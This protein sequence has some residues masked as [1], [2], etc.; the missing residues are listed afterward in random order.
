MERI[1]KPLQGVSNIVRFNWHFYVLAVGIVLA[2][3]MLNCALADHYT[4]YAILVTLIVLLPLIISLSVSFYVYDLSG[5]Y[6]LDWLSDLKIGPSASIININAGFDEIST[7]LHAR[8]PEASLTV[9]DFY[10]P[11]R[12]TEVSI[13]RARKAY[14]AYSGTMAISTAH[15]PLAGGSADLIFAV[16][17]AHEIRDESE[18]IV[19]FQELARVLKPNGILVLT[20]HLRDLPNFLAYNIG[21]FHFLSRASWYRVVRAAGLRVERER[22]ITPFISTFMLVKDG[23]AS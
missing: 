9:L 3:W 5:L 19:F 13:E 11:K 1:R 6:S 15:L 21:F 10:D 14:P 17:A 8:F 4:K 7:L 22:K 23:M 18:R 2:A 12:H 16:L 20:E